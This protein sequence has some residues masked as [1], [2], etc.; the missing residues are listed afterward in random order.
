MEDLIDLLEEVI[1][2]P[3]GT[4]ITREILREILINLLNK[5]VEL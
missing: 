5:T 1:K 2:L 3:K 4:I